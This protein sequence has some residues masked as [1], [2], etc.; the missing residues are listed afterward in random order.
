MLKIERSSSQDIDLVSEP[1]K[2]NSLSEKIRERIVFLEQGVQEANELLS[3]VP[4][5]KEDQVPDEVL[6]GTDNGLYAM[7]TELT[8]RFGY[9]VEDNDA[10]TKEILR[11]GRKGLRK[12]FVSGWAIMV[13]QG[14]PLQMSAT[15]GHEI[16]HHF[17]PEVCNEQDQTLSE[18][19]AEGTAFIVCGHYGLD[20]APQAFPYIAGYNNGEFTPEMRNGIKAASARM[21]EGMEIIDKSNQ[22]I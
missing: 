10:V 19:I 1:V 15:L 21:I 17:I 18:T 12:K 16:A 7:L 20:I 6:V 3:E 11:N 13:K 2:N 9:R 4:I 22:D 8:R 5:E 14:S